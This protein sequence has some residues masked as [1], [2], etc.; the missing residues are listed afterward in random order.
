MVQH[1]SITLATPVGTIC[2]RNIV[3]VRPEEPATSVRRYLRATRTRIALVENRNGKLE[4]VI[5][6]GDLLTIS[7]RKSNARVRDL[8]R[9]PLVVLDHDDTVEKAVKQLLRVDEWYAPVLKEEKIYGVFG[10]EHAI[11]RMLDEEEE[12]LEKIKTGEIMSREVETVS[13]DDYAINVWDKMRSLRYAGLPVV[14]E[15]GRLVGIVTQYD[16]LAKGVV[17]AMETSGGPAR[18]PRIREIMTPNVEYVT[19]E[20]PVTRVARLIVNRGY[21]R[22]P[23]VESRR[24]RKLVGIVD[25]EDIVRLLFASP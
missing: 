6:R 7:S 19:P 22:I 5:D 8:M 17:V 18:G 20:A 4:G 15:K 13:P 12:Y 9:E 23:V 11:Q 16:L 21:G 3:V 2:S 10:L 1:F 14:D 24:S 25:R